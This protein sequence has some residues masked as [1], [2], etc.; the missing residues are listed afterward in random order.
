MVKRRKIVNHAHQSC[1]KILVLLKSLRGAPVEKLQSIVFKICP[2]YLDSLCRKA[3]NKECNQ[4][5][6]DHRPYFHNLPPNLS[7]LPLFLQN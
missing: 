6:L 5:N 2:S 4:L 3:L 7:I 1:K